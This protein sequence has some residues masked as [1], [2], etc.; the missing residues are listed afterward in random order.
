VRT[1]EH[2]VRGCGA[3]CF[4]IVPR[5]NARRWRAAVAGG[6]GLPAS[7]PLSYVSEHPHSRVADA[8][9]TVKVAGDECFGGAGL[10]SLAVISTFAGEGRTTIAA[11]YA[12]IVAE[13]GLKVLLV[14]CDPHSAR[15]LTASIASKPAGHA[16][17]RQGAGAK[18]AV[19]AT[20]T[21][22]VVHLRE[23]LDFLSLTSGW[24]TDSEKMLDTLKSRYD[25]VVLDLPP[26]TSIADVRAAARDV[27]GFLL[28]IQWG[29]VTSDEIEAALSMAGGVQDRLLG[30]LLNN[31]KLR[32]TRWIPSPRLAFFRASMK[33]SARDKRVA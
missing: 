3:E 21:L 13:T 29:R 23:R 22:P 9:R 28:V 19:V 7:S 17:A 2:A 4:G 5:F 18:G 31:V 14:D 24:T 30:S 11:N 32:Q 25:Y 33:T 26:L 1:P 16:V 8:L 6:E 27:D 20:P 10:R 12:T 15:S